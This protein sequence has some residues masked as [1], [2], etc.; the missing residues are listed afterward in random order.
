MSNTAE[1]LAM[2]TS[3][4][5]VIGHI[6]GGIPNLTAADIAGAMGMAHDDI[7]AQMLL[8]KY[9]MDGAAMRSFRDS[10]AGVV[11]RISRRD[12]WGRPDRASALAVYTLAE[13]LDS[14]RC[15]SCKGVAQQMTPEGRVEPCPACDGIGLRISGDRPVAKALGMS[16]E[17]Y[18]KSPWRERA[19]WCRAEL[20]RRELTAVVEV[21][22]HLQG[23]R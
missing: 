13:W 11:A 10:W 6:P 16:N 5:V 19:L 18:R 2:L 15:R 7:S 8:A 4:G 17:G 22:R 9:A 14:Q 20:L 3:H 12:G 1:L 23:R 21:S